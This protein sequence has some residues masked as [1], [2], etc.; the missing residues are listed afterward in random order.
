MFVRAWC[1]AIV[2][3]EAW[4]TGPAIL[5]QLVLGAFLAQRAIAH[6]A[7]VP[8]IEDVEHAATGLAILPLGGRGP[9][10][11]GIF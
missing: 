4:P 6:T 1:W 10:I 8:P 5:R 3:V 2:S 11:C 9:S 7:M